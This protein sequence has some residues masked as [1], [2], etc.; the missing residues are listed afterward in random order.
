MYR[1]I[2]PVPSVCVSLCPAW[3][4]VAVVTSWVVVP[5]TELSVPTVYTATGADVIDVLR[6]RW[7]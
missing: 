1:V 4:Y 7:S 2:A 5:D 6:P 3:S